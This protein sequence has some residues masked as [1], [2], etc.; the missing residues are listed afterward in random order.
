MLK[1]QRRAR[2]TTRRLPHREAGAAHHPRVWG[3]AT[4]STKSR[5]KDRA[6]TPAGEAARA[7][8][9]ARDPMQPAR[10]AAGWPG[11]TALACGVDHQGD[12]LRG[13]CA[14]LLPADGGSARLPPPL[15]LPQLSHRSPRLLL[16]SLL[17]P[18]RLPISRQRP[19]PPPSPQLPAP[20][21]GRLRPEPAAVED[22]DHRSSRRCPRC[23]CLCGR[24]FRCRC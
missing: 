3:M 23:T 1:P 5:V 9:G 20:L 18:P 8:G 15:A 2:R 13:E 10:R 24:H 14:L 12:C 16:R 11:E 6:A 21:L 4:A 7:N 17:L 22:C 19:P